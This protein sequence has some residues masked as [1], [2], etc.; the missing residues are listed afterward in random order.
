MTEDIIFSTRSDRRLQTINISRAG[1]FLLQVTG[2]RSQVT[3]HRSHQNQKAISNTGDVRITQDSQAIYRYF[4][5]TN[6]SPYNFN[7][8]IQ[9][10][11]YFKLMYLFK[12]EHK[13]DTVTVVNFKITFMGENWHFSWLV[14]GMPLFKQQTGAETQHFSQSVVVWFA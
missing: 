9:T 10:S 6:V 11:Q 12:K 14:L 4:H 13:S 5:V 8:K 2:H 7:E 3:G 1:R